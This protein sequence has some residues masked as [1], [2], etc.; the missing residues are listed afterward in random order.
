MA[1][2]LISEVLQGLTEVKGKELHKARVAY[3]KSKDSVPL[4][5]VL[6]INF[7]E[8]V[9]SLLPKGEPPY[10]KDDAPAGYEH[11]SLYKGYRKFKYF[12]KGIYSGMD[13]GKREKMFID[14]LESLNGNEAEMLVLAK[15]GNLYDAYKGLTLKVVQDAFPGLITKAPEKKAT[16]KKKVTTEK[17]TKK[18]KK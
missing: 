16:V 12:F 14:L 17:T 9:V 7:D 18:T 13:Q 2:P 3:L 1:K 15:D 10:T 5:D 4:R 11:L 6:R 8:A